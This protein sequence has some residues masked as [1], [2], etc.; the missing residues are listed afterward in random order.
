[1]K[2]SLT[3]LGCK[4]NQYE[5]SAIED[6]LRGDG[7]EICPS[8]ERVD[9]VVINTCAVTSESGRK[10]KQAVRRARRENP[11]AI[12]AVCG[13]FSQISPQEV[14]ELGA[15]MV[16]GSGERA[17]FTSA[18][19]QAV[20]DKSPSISIDNPMQRREF[21]CLTAQSING[22]TRAFIKIQDGCDNFC[23]YCIIPFARGPVRS[24]PPGAAIIQAKRLAEDGYREIVVTGIEIASYG[25]DLK[26]GRNLS[27]IVTEIA[28]AVPDVRIRLGSL[29]PRLITGEFCDTISK[30]PKLCRHFHLSLQSGCDAT[31]SRMGRKYDTERF[32]ASAALLR[33]YYPDCAITTDLIVGF[34]GEDEAEFADTLAFIQKCRFAD[35]HIF[36]YSIRPGTK[37]AD[38]PGQISKSAKSQRVRLASAAARTMKADYLSGLVGSHLEVLFENGGSEPTGHSDNYCL[39]KAPGASK[40]EVMKVLISRA[41]DGVLFG[42]ICGNP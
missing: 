21:E 23:A 36:P 22:R 38:M 39:V 7:H 26:D 41:S 9:A 28:K 31:L 5:S 19:E 2:V 35:M 33:K 15:D 17:G 27:F 3:T 34:P 8:G 1:M 42:E 16:Y 11:D 13:C 20:N 29:E 6:M 12:I 18:L 24:M 32:C 30:I 40:G 10:S 14:S 25:K 37:A 4:V